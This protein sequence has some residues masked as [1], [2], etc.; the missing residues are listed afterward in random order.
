MS[1]GRTRLRR[2]LPVSD[3]WSLYISI[4]TL[5]TLA[6]LGWLL[7]ASYRN[8]SGSDSTSSKHSFDGIE[9]QNNPLPRWWLWLFVATLLFALAYLLLYPGLGNWR[10]LLPGYDALDTA[11]GVP[12]ADGRV[13]WSSVHQWEREQAQAQ[14]QYGPLYARLGATPIESLARDT[15]A[16]TIAARLFASNCALCH[17]V[18]GRG[19]PGYPN[20]A[21]DLWR[22][23]G[24]S[25]AITASIAQGRHGVMPAWASVVGEQGSRDL[26]AYV[27][28]LN[29]RPL[30]PG[31][32]ADPTRGETLY[33]QACVACHG[34]E[35]RGNPL[36]GAPDLTQARGFLYG[37][38][39][40]QIYQSIHN[41]RQGQMPA[42][43]SVLG[44]DRVHLLAAYV[45][46]LARPADPG[47]ESGSETKFETGVAQ[48]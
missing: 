25:Q 16:M 18:D 24:D 48:P 22:W 7:L 33:R 6:G 3:F 36:L 17:G 20:L 1:P 27:L 26:A 47:T 32:A 10:G 46:Q 14:I 41:G 40:E 2:K 38:G 13:G 8:D 34:P 28:R 4:L 12:F 30:P 37:A 23:G 15:Q 42:Q 5:G 44:D 43:A 11:R 29:D 9:E 19:A 45:Y 35:G 31:V 21:D 39:F